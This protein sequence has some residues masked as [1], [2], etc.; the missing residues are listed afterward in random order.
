M[1][2]TQ[3]EA[4]SYDQITR[5]RQTR[6]DSHQANKQQHHISAPERRDALV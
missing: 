4:K 5:Q 2:R 3:Q 6:T 1:P